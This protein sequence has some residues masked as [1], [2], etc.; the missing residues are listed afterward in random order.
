MC[1]WWIGSLGDGTKPH[2]R[3]RERCRHRSLPSEPDLKLSLHPA[4]AFGNAPR[5]TQRFFTCSCSCGFAHGNAH[6]PVP[7]SATLS[8]LPGSLASCDAR[9]MSSFPQIVFPHICRIGPVDPATASGAVADRPAFV[10][11][12]SVV[13]SP[14][15]LPTADHR[16]LPPFLSAHAA[17]WAPPVPASTGPDAPCPFGHGSF[18][19]R[20]SVG[21][22]SG[23]LKLGRMP[24]QMGGKQLQ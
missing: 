21:I 15:S 6:E 1:L 5:G 4:Q 12:A 17:G 16:D 24:G 14:D 23:S 20:S 19:E 18:R 2:R 10:P 3:V 13:E 9:A 7:G 8:S 11:S 22:I